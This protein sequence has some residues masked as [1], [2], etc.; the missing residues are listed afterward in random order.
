MQLEMAGDSC[1][2][3]TCELIL[4]FIMANQIYNT[5]LYYKVLPF[6]FLNTY[7]YPYR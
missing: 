3:F 5:V 1:K 2:Y 4:E 7:P 6:P